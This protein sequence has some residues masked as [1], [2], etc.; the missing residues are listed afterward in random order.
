M[1]HWH[2]HLAHQLS[3]PAKERHW[4]QVPDERGA[5]IEPDERLMR[6]W[7]LAGITTPKPITK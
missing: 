1:N 7:G 4:P 6:A 2:D 5:P 3:Q